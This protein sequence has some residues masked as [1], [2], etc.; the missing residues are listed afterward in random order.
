MSRI[1]K[2]PIPIADGAKVT[3]NGRVI[4]VEGP[5]GKDSYEHRPEVSVR[6]D[7]EANAVLV[8]RDNDER[9]SREFH[10]LTRALVAN[11][12][13]GVTKGYE[14]KLE[15]VGVGYLAAISGDTLQVRAGFANELHVKIPSDLDVT[16]PDQ[17]HVVVQGFN[18]QKV[19]QF[20]AEVRAL[21]KPEPYKGKGV[22]YQG[23]QVKIKP[24]KSA[25]K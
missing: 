9:A 22:R 5:K 20:A 3:I 13:E 10:G 2:K 6:L 16:C 11:M 15:I 17:T 4:D 7:E 19:G 18:K 23:E 21:R 24:G 1:G 12:I 14:K 25:S 8:E